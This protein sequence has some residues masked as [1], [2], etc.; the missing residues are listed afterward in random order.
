M[1]SSFPFLSLKLLEQIKALEQAISQQ[2]GERREL[3]GQLDK[4]TEDHTS[5]NQNTESMVGKIQVRVRIY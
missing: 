1:K 4:I 3:I 5:A 2:S